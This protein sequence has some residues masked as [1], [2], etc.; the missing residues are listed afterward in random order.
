MAKRRKPTG[1]ELIEKLSKDWLERDGESF[2]KIRTKGRL[3]WEE[4]LK[5]GTPYSSYLLES[6]SMEELIKRAYALAR[7]T[8]SAMDIPSKVT[9]R[10]GG[11]GSCTEGRNVYV[12]TDYFDDDALATGEKLDIFLGL[13]AHEGS[14]LLYTE[15]PIMRKAAGVHPLCAKLLNIIE[16]ERIERN[17]GE[18]KPGLANYLKA[19]KRHYFGRYSG[20]TGGSEDA[21]PLQKI[22]N[23]ILGLIRYPRLLREEEMLEFG[24]L[25]LKVE[26]ILTP[27][28]D[29]TASAE[30]AAEKI[31]ELIIKEYGREGGSGK[32][33]SGEGKTSPDK[34]EDSTDESDSGDSGEGTDSESDSGEDNAEDSGEDRSSERSREDSVKAMEKDLDKI[35]DALEEVAGGPVQPEVEGCSALRGDQLA[36]AVS[37]DRELL[38]KICEGEVET[39]SSKDVIFTR[40][41][42]YRDGY[43][44]A[45]EE[46]KQYVPAVRKVVKGRCVEYSLTHLGMRSGVLDTGKLAEAVQGVPTVYKRQGE[47]RSDRACV[48]MLVDESGSMYRHGRMLAAR[49]TAVLL[50]EALSSIP[51]IELFIYGH[52]ADC[53]RSGIT[54]L[55]IYREKGFA[56]KYALGSLEPRSNNRDGLAILETALRVRK[57]TKEE[58]LMFII[59]DGEPAAENY[60][61][62]RAI[63]HTKECVKKAEAMGFRIVQICINANYDPALM[64]RHF[65]KME[66]LGT[67]AR[68]LGRE[69]AKALSSKIKS[70]VI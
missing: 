23:C 40:Q 18:D 59:S 62:M 39:G 60:F 42:E 65:I 24:E 34:S 63:G 56:P 8:I 57:Q 11:G 55:N 51:N 12:A 5:E 54:E 4:S 38:A 37:T 36:E 28:P 32:K 26:K 15:F 50:N 64:F 10:L 22:L 30:R 9:V 45:L 47:V 31:F 29:S 61:G 16:D 17:L 43:M 13:T 66:N 19:V 21:S 27:Y 2:V 53:E 70:H 49:K 3:G 41:K 25:L 68:D 69:I 58:V 20:M 48:C 1:S 67:L 33:D 35:A 52:T 44:S 14:H 6:P 46:V 7:N